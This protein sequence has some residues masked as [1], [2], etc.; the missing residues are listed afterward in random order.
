MIKDFFTKGN[1]RSIEAKKNIAASFFIKSISI[2]INLALVPL[3]IHYV[4]PT[5]YGIW[6]TLSSI[7]AWFSF[8]DIGFGNGLRNRFAEAKA[9][10]NFELA[11]I[12]VSTTYAF[13]IIIF[14][15]VWILFFLCNFFVD[16]SKILNAPSEMA[17]ELSTLAIIVFSFFCLQIVL[18]TINT[19]LIADQKPA[20]SSF[21]DMLGQLIALIIIFI[22]SKITSGSLLYLGIVFGFTPILTLI[23]SSIWLYNNQYNK[24][25]PGIEFVKFDYAKDIMKLGFKFFLIQISVIIIF[26]TSNFIISQTCGPEDVTM[27][28]IAYKYFSIAYMIFY[29]IISPFWTAFSDAYTKQDYFWMRRTL[30]KLQYI[31]IV[32]NLFVIIMLFLSKIAYNLWIG[33]I[34][35]IR[36]NVSIL[37]AVYFVTYIYHALYVQLI[38]GM[39]KIKL[40]LFV[41][42][43]GAIFNIPLALFLG[44]K[45]GVEGVVA[46]SIVFNLV[47]LLYAPRQTYLLLQNKA[48][49]I[50]NR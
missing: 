42:L 31:A 34:I 38:N 11:R 21:L 14:I 7:I 2:A 22:L 20:K 3:T 40:Q 15:I 37:I 28:N 13:L 44:R 10:G 25:A 36:T 12:Y 17:T 8:F 46:A 23:I 27:Y 19:V 50:W 29:I 39:G 30:K 45:F 1:E 35:V 41:V 5:Q 6:L 9:S 33:D 32:I 48:T 4:N 18:K 26:Q 43:F 24:I 49:G 47:I 16:W